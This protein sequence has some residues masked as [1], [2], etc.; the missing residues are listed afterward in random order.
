MAT[1]ERSKL[2]RRRDPA[3]A[4]LYAEL[5]AARRRLPPGDADEIEF[6]EAARWLRVRRGAFELL[7]NFAA[8]AQGVPC[9]GTSAELFT[10]DPP[11]IA[12]GQ[13]QLPSMSGAL[14]A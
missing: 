10:H 3:L 6:D 7:C 9:V 14:I 12:D 4:G 13:A 8:R 11:R 1:F 2:T 5:L